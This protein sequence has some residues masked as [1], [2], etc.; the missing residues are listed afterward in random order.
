MILGILE[1]NSEQHYQLQSLLSHVLT[2]AMTGNYLP[3]THNSCGVSFMHYIY[4]LMGGDAVAS[5]AVGKTATV[6]LFLFF[7]SYFMALWY[8]FGNT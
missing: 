5:I 8:V 7:C 1:K 6:M 2:S 3:S 4:A